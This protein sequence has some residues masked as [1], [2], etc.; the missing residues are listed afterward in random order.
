[1]QYPTL[2][3]N[4]VVATVRA[5]LRTTVRANIV[6]AI[7][8][9]IVVGSLLVYINHGDH[10]AQEPVCRHFWL[11]CGLTYLVPFMVSMVSVVLSVT[12]KRTT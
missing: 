5:T 8:I 11:K 6:P 9:S 7:A 12:V 10:L 4:R 3:R 2:V 1:M